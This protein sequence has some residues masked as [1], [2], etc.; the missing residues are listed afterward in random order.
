MPKLK[1]GTIFPTAAEDAAITS[2]ALNDP[3]AQPLSPSQLAAMRPARGRGRPA[4]S[5][6]KV[7]VTMRFDQ[8][9]VEAFKRGGDGWQSRMNGALRE[10]LAQHE[11]V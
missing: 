9:I 2:A 4:G 11:Q 3:D 5:G 6:C 8:D 7:Q 10:W 1:Q